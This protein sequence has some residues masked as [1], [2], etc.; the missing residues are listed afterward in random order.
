MLMKN[1][2]T[3]KEIRIQAVIVFFVLFLI[4]NGYAHFLILSHKNEE[5]MK[6]E[7]TA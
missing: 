3:S 6:A 7:Y 1:R 2:K 5:Q 4:I